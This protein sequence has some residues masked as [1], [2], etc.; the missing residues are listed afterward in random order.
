MTKNLALGIAHGLK[1]LSPEL[2][3]VVFHDPEFKDWGIR[4]HN[5]STLIKL[6]PQWGRK[7]NDAY[8]EEGRLRFFRKGETLT[9]M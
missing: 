2:G 4:V 1:K 5:Y 7:Q 3:V 9:I 6:F 8:W